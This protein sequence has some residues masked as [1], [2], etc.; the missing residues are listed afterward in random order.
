LA[1]GANAD[2][3]FPPC[4]RGSPGTTFQNWSFA[5]SNNPAPPEQFNN[6]GGTPQ[7]TFTIG[8]AGTGWR[9]VALA[10]TN[11]WDLGRAGAASVA[12][13]NASGGSNS[14]KYVQVQVTYFEDGGIYVAPAVSIPGAT[15]VSSQ[16]TNNQTAFPGAWKTMLTVW[17]MRPAPANETVA[18]TGSSTKGFLLDQVIVDTRSTAP[19]GDVPAFRP[20]WRGQTNSSFQQ[21]QFGVS[22][23][24]AAIYPEFATNLYG[25]PV[26][27]IVL[28]PFSSAYVLDNPFLGCVQG[29]WDLGRGGTL[30]LSLPNN[31]GASG[32]SY[33]YV[34]VQVTQYRDSIYNTNAAVN[35]PGGVLVGRQEQT[36]L[37]T[38]NVLN[39][40]WVAE[41]TVWR[42]GPPSPGAEMVVITGG[43][44]GALV[45]QVVAD[46]LVVDI[47]CPGNIGGSAD[48]GQC[49]KS[50][51]T[52]SVPVV[53]GCVVTNVVCTPA[54]GSTFPVGTN[55][56]S[57]VISDSEG[58]TRTCN[59]NVTITDDEAPTVVCPA[60]ITVAKGTNGCGAYVSFDPVPSDNCPGATVQSIPP[61]GSLFP[62]GL[63][64]VTN[65]AHDHA[66]NA[67]APCV[68]T[69]RVVDFDGDVAG[70]RP[71]WRGLPETTFQQWAFSVSNNPAALL[72]ELVTNQY[73]SASAAV[74]PGPFSSGYVEQNPFLGCAQGIW[75]LGRGGTLTLSLPNSPGASSG[76]YKYVSV[77]VTQYR[78]SIYNTNAAVNVPGGV[79]VGRQEQ[80]VLAT[81][82]VLNGIWVAEQTVW[83]LGPPSPGAEMVVI[84]GG[85]NG[86]LIDQVVADT[87]VV[88]IPCPGNIGGSADPGQCGKSNVTWSVPVV[89]GCVVTNVVCTPANGSTFPVGTNV[90][91][92]V[93]SDSEGGTRT[94]NFNVTITDDE[95]P[96]A[97]C[98]NIVVNLDA[99]GEAT[100]TA[101]DVD[102]GSSDNCGIASRSVS[103]N[104]FTCGNIGPNLVQLTVVDIH[105]HASSCQATVTVQDS[106]PPVITC[107]GG[108]VVSAASGMCGSNVT[109]VVGAEDNCGLS[110]V[111]SVPASGSPFPVGVTIVTNTATDLHGNSSGCTFT[112]TVLDQEPPVITAPTNMVVTADLGQ[113]TASN[114]AFSVTASDNCPGQTLVQI[115]GLPSGSTFPKGVTTNIFQATDHAGNTATATF[116]VTVDD[117]E[118]PV[119]S[120]VS[121]TQTQAGIGAV[122]VKDCANPTIQGTVAIAVHASDTCALLTPQ[123]T[124]TNGA[125]SAT[126][127][128]VNESPAG[129]FNY[130]WAVETN[131]ANGAWVATVVASDGAN[132]TA[133]SFSLCVNTAE[134]AGVIQMDTFRFGVTAAYSFGRPVTFT[135]TDS[136]GAPLMTWNIT[137]G[138]TNNIATGVAAG[139][140]VLADVPP[141][142]ANISAKTGWSLRRRLPVTFD[143]NSQAHVDFSDAARLLGGDLN[144]NNIVNLGDY[145]I[146]AVNWLQPAA[147]AD[148][149]GDGIAN[150]SDYN[151][152]ASYWFV[153]GDPP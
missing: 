28:G 54:N 68:F 152:L 56:V 50:N 103:N 36:V 147:A 65:I 96:V 127:T 126:A 142:T 105:D 146:L 87:L 134:V 5:A 53:D 89:D 1:Q 94:C 122:D 107:P 10:R 95:A 106:L 49:G 52:W 117:G 38:G 131:T 124:L 8:T 37:A 135:A 85:T 24:P 69:V 35:V 11:V 81:S 41:Q 119:I 3:S 72:P 71:C 110:S 97:R 93:I 57:V 86:A 27:S 63:T 14:W 151:I 109:F 76:S 51:V 84:T 101:A 47:P 91:S 148:I 79:L 70:Y 130:T 136:G 39:G 13:P 74:V 80:T 118:P 123:V 75:D 21:W 15:L 90:V 150:L 82:N 2:D 111:V 31:P 83:R 115:S 7:T 4:W 140:Y 114:V 129:V 77:Q 144:G 64:T 143:P 145:N 121:A 25:A 128:F 138:F 12:I 32:G 132:T 98:T 48:P 59:F 58:G 34:S 88:D 18:L 113:C 141:A 66:G 17:Q 125:F 73:G 20:C 149:N 55:V 29:I 44:N 61:S 139:S 120:S 26:A 78:D 33:K 104:V 16:V 45:D 60:D 108:I 22:N 9:S 6:P 43:T 116:T 19:G 92:V 133:S 62:L 153:T 100:I 30:T 102:G 137:I 67:S 46:T 23:N 112:V 99:L 40:I 42:L